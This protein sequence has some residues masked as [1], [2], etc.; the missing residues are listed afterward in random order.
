MKLSPVPPGPKG[1]FLVGSLLEIQKDELDF[2]TRQ[3]QC[4]LAQ[5]AL[6]D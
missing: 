5:S 6:S 1:R 3:V 4:N 2:L